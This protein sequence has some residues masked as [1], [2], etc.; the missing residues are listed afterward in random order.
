MHDFIECIRI[1][2]EILPYYG[3]NSNKI[4]NDKWI[5]RNTRNAIISAVIAYAKTNRERK[6]KIFYILKTKE[7]CTARNRLLLKGQFGLD[8]LLVVIANLIP[9]SLVIYIIRW[10]ARSRGIPYAQ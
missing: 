4:L 10:I 3:F 1:R 8:I 5:I 2:N 7:I 6:E 9:L